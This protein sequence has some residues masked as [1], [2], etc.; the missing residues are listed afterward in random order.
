MDTNTKTDTKDNKPKSDQPPTTQTNTTDK[1]TNE[2]HD[3]Y[4][5][6][7]QDFLVNLP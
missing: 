7:V 1:P 2:A 5:N 6:D 3:P 4:W